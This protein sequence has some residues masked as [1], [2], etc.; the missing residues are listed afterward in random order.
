MAQDL[1]NFIPE[2]WSKKLSIIL[3]NSG[4]MMQC[5]NKDFE[6]EIKNSGDTVRIRSFGDVTVKTY[7]GS[8]TYDELTSP[9]QSLLIDQK[10]YFAFKVDDVSKAQSNI[11]IM[12]GY[13][14]RAK[15]AI[16]LAKDSFLLA[17][18]ADV[19][20][21][22]T[23]GTETGPI[24]LTSDNIYSNFVALGKA[25]KNS[26][27]VSK[28]QKPF[29]IINPDIEA[30]LIQADEFIQ[31]SSQGEKTLREGS[32][33]KIAGLD[34]LVCTNLD[35]VDSKYY[36]MAGT[37][38]AVTFASQV[39]EVESLRL[40]DSFDTAVRGLYVYGAKTV[41]PNALAKLICTIS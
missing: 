2:I 36:V 8:I 25:L 26:N 41:V 18:H 6:G 29:I 33:G 22:N 10:K 30:L 38:N 34:V 20:S 19:P 37:N 5:V 35:A 31:A 1:T 4:V 12:A 21:A 11:D 39:V 17:K 27:A 3:D 7:S 40:Q 13:L 15:V 23:V 28:G 14:E 16:D 24:A 9:T 32:I